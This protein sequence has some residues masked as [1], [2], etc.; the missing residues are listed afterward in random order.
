MVI[1]KMASRN[2]AYKA[3]MMSEALLA[4]LETQSSFLLSRDVGWMIVMNDDD[5]DERLSDHESLVQL[6]RYI[7]L[8]IINHDVIVQ[9]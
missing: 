7:N 2:V 9:I 5:D 6:D 4:A 1:T 3:V 8:H